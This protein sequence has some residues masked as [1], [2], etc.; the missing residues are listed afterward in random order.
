MRSVWSESI[1]FTVVRRTFHC[2]CPVTKTKML[3][4]GI[5]GILVCNFSS[6]LH[7]SAFCVGQPVPSS[8]PTL[9]TVNTVIRG[10]LIRGQR[11]DFVKDYQEALCYCSVLNCRGVIVHF[12][13]IKCKSQ[14]PFAEICNLLRQYGSIDLCNSGVCQHSTLAYA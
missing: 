9:E 4:M 10:D 6:S 1:F 14:H 13:V 5:Y 8:N 7:S 3:G 12:G 11:W 2:N